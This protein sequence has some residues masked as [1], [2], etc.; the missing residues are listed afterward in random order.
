MS[1]IDLEGAPK[2]AEV[3]D[4][5][6]LEHQIGF[7]LRKVHQRASDIFGKV[8]GRF[9]VTPTQ[10]AALAKLHDLDECS[11]NTL[12]R[13]AAMDPAT[14]FGVVS[15]LKR[16]G[17][18]EQRLDPAD[19]RRILLSLTPAGR[20]AVREMR[21]AAPEVSRRTLDQL[22]EKEARTLLNILKKLQ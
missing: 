5:Y 16:R 21:D 10:F 19:G 1:R 8:M 18:V 6:V 2:P 15:R 11:Q 4:E 7:I 17:L 22:S 13:A 12:G 14:I 3:T 20:G 9:E